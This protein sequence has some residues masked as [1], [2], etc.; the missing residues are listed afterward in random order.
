LEFLFKKVLKNAWKY[1]TI[2]IYKSI[3][4]EN[5]KMR[6]ESDSVGTLQVPAEAYYGVQTQ[7]GYENFQI[8][9]RKMH[10]DFVKN[11]TLI[12]KVKMV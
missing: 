12:K 10:E 5:M 7:R 8:S 1:D 6:R 4:E 11:I 3:E 9:D 2:N